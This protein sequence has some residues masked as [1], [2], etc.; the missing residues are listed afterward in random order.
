MTEEIREAIDK[1][2]FDEYSKNFLDKYQGK[3]N[4]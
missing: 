1:G 4:E 3:N 2:N